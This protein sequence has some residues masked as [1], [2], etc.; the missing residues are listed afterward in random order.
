ME[1]VACQLLF[2]SPRRRRFTRPLRG[3]RALP[4]GPNDGERAALAIGAAMPALFDVG[5]F[6]SG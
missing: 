1:G 6:R 5:Q 2:S 4:S 3:P